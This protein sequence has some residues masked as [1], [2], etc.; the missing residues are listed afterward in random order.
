MKAYL[1]TLLQRTY[2]NV[3]HIGEILLYIFVPSH[4]LHYVCDSFIIF[5]RK[6]FSNSFLF[7]YAFLSIVRQHVEAEQWK[8]IS[9]DK[10]TFIWWFIH[11]HTSGIRRAFRI[12][13]RLKLFC[14]NTHISATLE[15]FSFC[16]IYAHKHYK[17]YLYTCMLHSG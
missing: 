8:K 15:L 6:N 11:K 14:E 9:F 2:E 17:L 1:L 7:L 16:F 5:S 12:F 3:K 4:L 13:V 10:A